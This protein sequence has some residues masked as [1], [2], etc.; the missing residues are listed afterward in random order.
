MTIKTEDDVG[1]D[2]DDDRDDEQVNDIN[3]HCLYSQGMRLIVLIEDN[4][5][6]H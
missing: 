2:V 6:N 1:F 5:V 4:Y 3:K